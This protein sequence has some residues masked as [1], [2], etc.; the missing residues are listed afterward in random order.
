MLNFRQTAGS[1]K[2]KGKKRKCKNCGC[3][4]SIFIKDN[5]SYNKKG[6]KTP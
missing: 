4:A 3:K 6:L 1:V 5:E 2:I